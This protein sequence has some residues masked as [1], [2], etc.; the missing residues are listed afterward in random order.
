MISYS[1]QSDDRIR[2]IHA[3]LGAPDSGVVGGTRH[4]VAG[5]YLYYH[6]MQDK[7]NDKGWGCAY[8][9]LQVGKSSPQYTTQKENLPV[10]FK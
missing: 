9:S 6:Y 10:V 5:D 3:I 8:R 1:A 2:N 7:F 4:M